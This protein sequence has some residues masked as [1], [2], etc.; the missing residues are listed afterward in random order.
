MQ[1][2]TAMAPIKSLRDLMT[3]EPFYLLVKVK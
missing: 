3:T 2:G 1:S